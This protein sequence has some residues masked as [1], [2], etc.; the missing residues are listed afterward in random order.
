MCSNFAL[1]IVSVFSQTIIIYLQFAMGCLPG[2]ASVGS[3]SIVLLT[4]V[5]LLQGLSVGGQLMSSLVFT[6]ERHPKSKWGLYGSYVMAAANFGTLLGGLV[7][8]LIRR[9]LSEEALYA[10][11]WRIP[12]LSGILVSFSG[13]YLKHHGEDDGKT[14][15]LFPIFM[16]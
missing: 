9:S 5:R 1:C 11:G 3:L 12:F 13:Y 14:D 7:A 4:I 10:W 15:A 6:L 8:S 2:Y 16:N